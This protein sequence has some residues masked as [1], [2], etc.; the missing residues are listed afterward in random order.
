MCAHGSEYVCVWSVFVCFSHGDW[1]LGTF[2]QM[3]F[4]FF[5]PAF[6]CTVKNYPIM[7]R[8]SP[9]FRAEKKRRI[10]VWLSWFSRSRFLAL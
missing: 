2:L 4:P 7:W 8:K 5:S 10:L 1:I 9:D 3:I 6:F